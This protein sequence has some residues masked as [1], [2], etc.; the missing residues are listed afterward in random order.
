MTGSLEAALRQAVRGEV[1]FGSST[2]AVYA[3]DSSN[4][5]QVPIGVVFP[6]DTDDL[7][8]AVR[9]CADHGVPVLGRGA[10]TSLAGQACNVA[11]VLDTS[12][13]MTRILEIDPVRRTARVQPG[14]VLDD[15]RR[16]AEVH[17]LTFGPDPATHA[18]CTL[19]GMI[20]NNSCGTHALYAGKTVDNVESLTVVTYD[21]EVLELGAYDD[22]AYAAA[23]VAGG[24]TA[25]VLG[26]LREIG[27]RH[28]ALVRERYVDIP[29]RVSGYNLDQLLPDSGFHVARALVGTE[30]TCV[31]VAE[32]TVTLSVSPAHRRLVVLGYPDVF[33]AADAVPSLL[34]HG[35]L[36]LEGFDETLERQMRDRD[37]HVQ[38]LELLPPG[39]GWLLAEL[40]ADDPAEADAR[41]DAFTAALP[42]GVAWRRFDD[43]TDQR[44]VWLVR[45]SG[46]G[47]T[48]IRADG[49][50][51][52][53]GWED[54]AVA[55]ERLGEYLRA[56]TALWDDYGY[57]GAWYG[58]FGQGCVHTRNDFDL[59]TEQGLR[60][61]RSY[62]ERAADLVV[63]MGGSLSGEH[64]DGQSRG[65]LL[66]R[67]YGPE[68][69]DAFRQ[70]KAVFDPRGRMNPGKVV[71]AYP[72][73]SSLR[74]GPDHRV[75]RPHQQFFALADDGGSLQTAVE[76]CVGVGR[77]RRDDAGT[78]CPSYR[79]TRDERHSTRG[80]AKLLAEMF[81]GEVTPAT[82]RNDDVREALDLCLSCKGCQT[83][84][85]THVD[86]ATYKAEFLSHHYARR[87]RPRV[88]YALGL[89]PWAARAATAVPRA[90]NLVLTAPGLSQ[91]VRR[92]AGV[93]TARPAPRFAATSWRRTR[94]ARD[95]ART[96]Q[97]TVV[98]W[99][100]TFTDAYSPEVGERLVEL[101]ER[102]GERVVVPEQWGCCGRP[103]YD[104]GMLATARRTLAG[105]LDVLQPWLD[106][107]LPVV[108]P[109]PSCLSTF[110]D[111]LPGLLPD[112]PRA[113]RL[114]S[115][116]R[117]PAEQL[118]ASSRLDG[119]L[120]AAPHDLPERLV[121]HP[122][123]HARAGAAA[124][125]DRELLQRLGH[126][127][128]VLDAGCCGLAG[129]FGFDAAHEPLSR[130]IG[131]ESWLPQVRAALGDDRLV[132]DGFS[133]R[134]QLDHL[135]GPA[136]TDLVTLAWQ[137]L[138]DGGQGRPAGVRGD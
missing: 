18:W 33:A 32:A 122:H 94:S 55:P 11:V 20:G 67:M 105:L 2:R 119:A 17:G 68:L 58:H 37:L 126:E 89:L 9:V 6:R 85:P 80:R 91:L 48:A 57:S 79:V 1:E 74:F 10:G 53:E 131:E 125:A 121:I 3:T 123:C 22:S 62:V 8:A 109:E 73:D 104:A 107:G 97:P 64:G 72:L 38:H 45:E 124:P 71:D 98:V 70:F 40:G 77:C 136:A 110:R 82:W 116:A 86:M 34:G 135:G 49:R 27:R 101:L 24:R 15:L 13:H 41:T 117:S 102:L 120:A 29:R 129:S 69:V 78:M 76:R 46:L 134:T 35:L 23:V 31:L 108:V 26:G 59:H 4:Y 36:G 127:A 5:R 132:A 21:G 93:T 44:R 111:E 56:V 137:R 51:N 130:R 65:E 114:A 12:R 47:A 52:S 75:V 118:L 61:Y 99:P 128:E 54:A 84:C 39:G 133:C 25:E 28:E 88:M 66:E 63:S 81:Q 16:A 30:S 112:D 92:A 115:L 100:D 138:C 87:L 42:D 90:A 7:V 95:H 60:D 14:V 19:G 106:R 113:A 50:H 96:S 103:L 43:E 83:D